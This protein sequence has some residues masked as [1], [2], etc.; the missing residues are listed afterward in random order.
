M[1]SWSTKRKSSYLFVFVAAIVVLIGLPAFFVFYKSPTCSDGVKN[2]TERGVDCGGVCAKLCPADFAAPRVLWAYSVK[3]VPGIYNAL[4]YIQ[5]PNASVEALN[6]PYLIK[7]YDSEGILITQKTGKAFVPAGQKFAV[8]V[9]GID[10]GKRFPSRT[11]F[12]FIGEPNWRQGA[13]LTQIRTLESSLDVQGQPKA[14]VRIKNDAVDQGFSNVS[15]FIILYDKN[16]NRISFSK[17]VID[18][19]GPSESQTLYFTWP[20][21][22]ASPVVRT[23]VLFVLNPTR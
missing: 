6:L 8:F 20:E 3:V 19:I 15:A 2:G 9:G 18:S 12:E 17:T 7:L 22:F 5:N 10:T 16:D 21:P 14:E 23:E 1:A 13:L 4:A 11:T